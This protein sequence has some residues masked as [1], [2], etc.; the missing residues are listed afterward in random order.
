MLFALLAYSVS[1][2]A[3]YVILNHTFY[4]I[5]FNG[6]SAQCSF[7]HFAYYKIKVIER[8]LNENEGVFSLQ[9]E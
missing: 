9:H 2:D 5:C 8:A 1:Y 4:W 6:I 3:C 7:L